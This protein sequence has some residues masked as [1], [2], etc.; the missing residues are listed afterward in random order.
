[1]ASLTFAVIGA[2]ISNHRLSAALQQG[3][4]IFLVLGALVAGMWAALVLRDSFA[5]STKLHFSFGWGLVLY[6]LGLGLVMLLNLEAF[7]VHARS[8]QEKL[9]TS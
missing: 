2:S 3:V 5:A 9:P 1:M 4:L 7:I 8:P 6:I